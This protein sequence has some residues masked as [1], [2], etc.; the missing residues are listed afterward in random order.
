M[1]VKIK[2]AK[3]TKQVFYNEIEKEFNRLPETGEYLKIEGNWYN[4]VET[5]I[6]I[7]Q[8][9]PVYELYCYPFP[10]SLDKVL[11]YNNCGSNKKLFFAISCN[12]YKYNLD[13]IKNVVET[14]ILETQ[15]YL[16]GKPGLI[17]GLIPSGCNEEWEEFLDE[18]F[19]RFDFY[20]PVK[21]KTRTEEMVEFAKE[22]HLE[23]TFLFALIIGEPTE[24]VREEMELYINAGVPIQVVPVEERY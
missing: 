10:F 22:K 7:E 5:M 21:L 14:Q 16:L 15:L 11:K 13:D 17:N 4:V 8:E 1:K 12:P 3:N 18:N 24:E 19:D 6:D 23:G 2:Y 9:E 20:D